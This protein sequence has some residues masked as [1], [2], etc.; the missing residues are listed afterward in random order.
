MRF[1]LTTVR[2]KIYILCSSKKKKMN[3]A[4]GNQSTQLVS[5]VK[6]HIQV[7]KDIVLNRLENSKKLNV[8]LSEVEST[9]FL[10]AIANA[11]K[12]K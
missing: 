12:L 5:N 8:V 1:I 9:D 4:L 10:R 7:S 6:K 2:P 11:E 3:Q